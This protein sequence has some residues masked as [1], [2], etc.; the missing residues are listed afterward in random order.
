MAGSSPG[1]ETCPYCKK[2]F[3]RLKSHLPHCKMAVNTHSKEVQSP[4]K[5]CGSATS[6]LLNAGEKGGQIQSTETASKQNKSKLEL[7]SKRVRKKPNFLEVLEITGT[8]TNSNPYLGKDVQKQTKCHTEKTHKTE[9]G[10]QRALEMVQAQPDKVFSEMNVA[11]NSPTMQ[12][13]RSKATS[14]E[15]KL[16]SGKSTSESPS[17]AM[18]PS[19]KQRQSK[20]ASA[21]QNVSSMLD[22]S[23]DHLQSVPEGVTDKKELV[24]ENH[25]VKALRNRYES[26]AQN[27]PLSETTTGNHKTKHLP[28]KSALGEEEMALDSG[29]QLVIVKADAKSML[30]IELAQNVWC[31]KIRNGETAIQAHTSNDSC[32]KVSSVP[33]QLAEGANSKMDEHPSFFKGEISPREP[34]VHTRSSSNTCPSWREALRESEDN[35][36]LSNCLTSLEK[37]LHSGTAMMLEG[38][39]SG[40]SLR[41]LT[42]LVSDTT[43]PHWFTPLDS[44]KQSRALGLE[45]FAELYPNYYYLGLFSKKQPQWNTRISEGPVPCLPCDS[46]QAWNRYYNKYINVK[47]GGVAGISMLLLLGYCV[48][49][50]TWSYKHIKHSRWRKYH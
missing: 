15:E 19:T 16:A 3:K 26:F 36:T 23:T 10:R 12:K 9:G 18:K 32:R 20:E 7:A 21:R 11:K 4:V 30:D 33:V 31:G 6:K 22:S 25:H 29:Q 47:K 27:I 1:I 14:E 38:K 34:P 45:W 35:G 13:S 17:Q 43:F 44:S 28:V 50:Y 24:I 39:N 42:P 5:V 48:L 40:V 41:Q 8:A 46:H 37:D 49:S 2:S